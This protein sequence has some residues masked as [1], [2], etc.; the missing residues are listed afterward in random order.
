MFDIN[1]D[2]IFVDLGH[3]GSDPGAV[4]NGIVEKSANLDTGLACISELRRH[5][6]LVE[7]SRTSD[8]YVSLEDRVAMANKLGAKYFISIHHNAGGGDRGEYIHSVYRGQGLALAEAIGQEMN[9]VVGQ[10]KK[11]Y[12]KRGSD[13]KDYFFVIRN[14]NMDA[15][16]VEVCF[17]DNAADVQI[18]DT[19]AERQR[20][21][22]TIAHGILKHLGISIKV[23]SVT[24]PGN[25]SAVA[26]KNTDKEITR[27]PE[28]GKCTITATSGIYFRNKPSVVDGVRQG[29]YSYMESVFYDLVVISEKYVWI[30]WISSTTGTRRYMPVKVRATGE[31]WGN[32]V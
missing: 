21:G 17:L 15:I 12:E 26:D 32:C 18:A 4:A 19:L 14:T 28:S 9:T 3:G 23:S 29:T 30:S 1:K 24:N 8:V 10:Q 11:V 7:A 13:N 22:I 27:Y 5:N 2:I 6:I 16:I 31:R 20:N 25:G